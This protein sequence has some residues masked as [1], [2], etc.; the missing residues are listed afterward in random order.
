MKD[1]YDDF[2]TPKSGASS[3][4]PKLRYADIVP[5][6]VDK[7]DVVSETNQ[8]SGNTTGSNGGKRTFVDL[9]NSEDENVE[10]DKAK[11]H[12]ADPKDKGKKPLFSDLDKE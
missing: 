4:K 2:V 11:K 12:L 1:L 9:D 7:N 3:S 8:E 6:D 10:T 5:F